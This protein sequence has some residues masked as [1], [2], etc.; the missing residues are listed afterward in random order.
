MANY[1]IE[2]KNRYDY[3]YRFLL[4][5]NGDYVTFKSIVDARKKCIKLIKEHIATLCVIRGDGEKLVYITELGEF[6]YENRTT[7]TWTMLREDGTLGKRV[8]PHAIWTVLVKS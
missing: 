8:N 4:K 2:Y 3:G 5:S 6:V 7:N 1:V